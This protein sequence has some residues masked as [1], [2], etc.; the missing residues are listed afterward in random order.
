MASL[1]FRYQNQDLH[2]LS[3]VQVIG[4]G[5]VSR[6]AGGQR[7][8]FES[9]GCATTSRPLEPVHGLVIAESFAD[10]AT[11]AYAYQAYAKASPERTWRAHQAQLE[12]IRAH[13]SFFGVPRP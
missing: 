10:S 1:V 11:G 13:M 9:T 5:S 4:R 12:Y 2:T 6:I 7:Q 8:V 3:N